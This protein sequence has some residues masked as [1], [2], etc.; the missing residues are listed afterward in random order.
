[1]APKVRGQRSAKQRGHRFHIRLVQSVD[2][3]VRLRLGLEF[4]GDI[5]HSLPVKPSRV[6]KILEILSS[7][8]PFEDIVSESDTEAEPQQK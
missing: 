3:L 2:T 1:M 4:K 8:I 5:G 7:G 6:V